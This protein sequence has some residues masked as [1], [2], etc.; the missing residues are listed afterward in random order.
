MRCPTDCS[1][2]RIVHSIVV[3]MKGHAKNI[4]SDVSW[5]DEQHAKIAST[6]EVVDVV[7]GSHLDPLAINLEKDRWELILA[8]S[9]DDSTLELPIIDLCVFE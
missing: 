5:H 7:L 6:R 4:H 3:D 1:F 9:D 8:R 2:D